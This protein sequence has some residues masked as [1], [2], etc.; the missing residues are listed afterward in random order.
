MRSKPGLSR[1]F[2][3]ICDDLA[4]G[5]D[6]LRPEDMVA[7]HPVLEAVGP[8]GVLAE[9]P[10]DRRRLFAGRVGLV[11]IAVL[12]ERIL[13]IERDRARLHHDPVVFHIDLEDPVHL[14]EDE[15]RCRPA[16]SRSPRSG[17]SRRRG[18]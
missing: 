2:P 18:R 3:P 8:A 7:G 1:D 4:V 12:G 15:R 17:S 5:E 13:Q 14:R 10:A 11:E 16:R 9:I 6:H